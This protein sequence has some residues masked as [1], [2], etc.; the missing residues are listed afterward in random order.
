MIARN[1]T[2]KDLDAALKKINKVFYKG[3]VIFK[4]L[5]PKG[6]SFTVTLRTKDSHK[7]GSTLTRSGR[8][9]PAACWHVH[10]N[11]FAALF[12]INPEATVITCHAKITKHYGNW[13]DYNVGSMMV[14]QYASEA[15]ECMENG[16][17]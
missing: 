5:E 7:S 1:C 6:K 17:L 11:F 15:C 13:V 2:I 3:N 10:G 9:I 12:K 4:H 14:P 8:H 16:L